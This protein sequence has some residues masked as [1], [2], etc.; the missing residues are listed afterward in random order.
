[1]FG[2]RPLAAPVAALLARDPALPPGAYAGPALTA[3]S[4]ARWALASAAGFRDGALRAA[5]FGG[6]TDV[7]G[8]IHGQVAGALHGAQAIPAGWLGALARR[9]LIEDVADR[10]LAA[11]L[12]R[13]AE[14][15]A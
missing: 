3:L 9:E 13:L 14:N 11:G 5:N 8:A 1:V 12:V 6:D 10:L 2:P 4:A 15:P 7:I